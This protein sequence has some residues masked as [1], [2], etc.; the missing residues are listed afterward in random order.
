MLCN[1]AITAQEPTDC[2]DAV[3]ACGN[4]QLNLDVDGVG[5]QELG[6]GVN[7]SS[8]ENNSVWL[9]VTTITSGTLGFTI[10]PSVA[11]INEDYD[12]FVFGPNVSCSAIGT[13][14]RCSL[15]ILCKQV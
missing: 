8:Q 4:S 10:R 12:F 2:I 9:K 13:A 1:G 7:C 14:I 15:Q 6:V 3:I 11:D 5:T